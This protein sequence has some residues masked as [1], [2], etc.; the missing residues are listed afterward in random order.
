MLKRGN[1]TDL[2]TFLLSQLSILI[3]LYFIKGFE[4]I[5]KEDNTTYFYCVSSF[6]STFSYFELILITP[7]PISLSIWL[8][9]TKCFSTL[10][11]FVWVFFFNLSKTTM[12]SSVFLMPL[13][14]HIFHPV[15]WAGWEADKQ[16]ISLTKHWG[17]SLTPLKKAEI[18]TTS[19]GCGTIFLFGGST[20]TF[21]S[22]PLPRCLGN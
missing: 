16:D 22:F 11:A 7:C 8:I 10:Y 14:T 19:S 17:R 3:I 5:C 4:I 1:L 20:S 12:S 21:G 18:R 2:V 15:Y 13:A 6:H 9:L